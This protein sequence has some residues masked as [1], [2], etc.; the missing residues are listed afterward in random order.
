MQG[1]FRRPV[2][3]PAVTFQVAPPNRLMERIGSSS[4]AAALSRSH[5]SQRLAFVATEQ[6]QQPESSVGSFFRHP[7]T[8]R[9]GRNRR[10]QP[11]FLVPDG[12]FVAFVAARNSRRLTHGWPPTKICDVPTSGRAVGGTWAP[13]AQSSLL[14]KT[15]TPE[16]ACAAGRRPERSPRSTATPPMVAHVPARWRH[17]LFGAAATG[18]QF[19]IYLASLDASERRLLLQASASNVAYSQDHLLFVRN[20][21]LMAQ[22]F[23]AG[24]LALS[25]SVSGREQIQLQGSPATVGV[26]SA[27]ETGS[28]AYQTVGSAAV[29]R[30]VWFDRNGTEIGTLG[31]EANY[32][33][34]QLSPDGR[35]MAVAVTAPGETNRDVWLYDIARGVRTRFTFDPADD[36]FPVWS[37][38]GRRIIF[39]SSRTGHLDLYQRR[40]EG[41]AVTTCCSPTASTSIRRVGRPMVVSCCTR[42]QPVDRSL[43]AA[44][45]RDRKPFPS[46]RRGSARPG[47]SSRRR[48]LVAYN[49]T[50]RGATKSM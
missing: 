42:G 20:G 14:N 23:D 27:S 50:N 40:S 43:G 33:H 35:R 47:A 9:A 49:R 34:V 31:D 46:S 22:S 25:G 13:T 7:G 18:S 38:D 3:T 36:T 48:P 11:S 39:T 26:F 21:T 16:G 4:G 17:L 45:V 24:R 2:S 6:G 37:P 15:A 30:L 12:R 1:Y 41:A 28:L 32:S 10:C 19:S 8:P 44:A 5:L 29:S